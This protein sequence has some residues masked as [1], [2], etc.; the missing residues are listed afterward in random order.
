MVAYMGSLMKKKLGGG[1]DVVSKSI[2][3][4]VEV[5]ENIIFFCSWLVPSKLYYEKNGWRETQEEER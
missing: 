5:M 4:C 3:L 2:F 1:V